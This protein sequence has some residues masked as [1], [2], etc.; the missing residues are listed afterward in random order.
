LPRIWVSESVYLM[1]EERAREMGVTVSELIESLVLGRRR[2][3][4]SRSR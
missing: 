3:S 1:L 4:G 2:G